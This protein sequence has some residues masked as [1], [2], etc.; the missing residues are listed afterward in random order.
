MTKYTAGTVGFW[1]LLKRFSGHSFGYSLYRAWKLPSGVLDTSS[2]QGVWKI[3]F[4]NEVC[5]GLDYGGLIRTSNFDWQ[6]FFFYSEG[7]RK[8]ISRIRPSQSISRIRPSQSQSQVMILL[9]AELL[10]LRFLS[11]SHYFQ[12]FSTIPGAGWNWTINSSETMGIQLPRYCGPFFTSGT[13]NSHVRAKTLEAGFLRWTAS[14]AS[15]LCLPL[16][17]KIALK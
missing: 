10:P 15:G 9:M 7:K 2:W 12:G 8:S 4:D 11:L 17:W 6:P 14:A 13:N 1:I 3:G 5:I 16:E